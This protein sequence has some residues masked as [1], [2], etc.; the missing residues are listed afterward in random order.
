MNFHRLSDRPK[1][2]YSRRRETSEQKTKQQS[3]LWRYPVC[4]TDF[5]KTNVIFLYSEKKRSSAEIL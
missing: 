3:C 4:A 1:G 5:C 2:E